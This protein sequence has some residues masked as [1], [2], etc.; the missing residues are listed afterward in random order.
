MSPETNALH[1]IQGRINL[2]PLQRWMAERGITDKGHAMHCL[3]RECFGEQAPQPFKLIYPQN[4]P[5]GIIY[6]YA[7]ADAGVLQDTAELSAAPL[8]CQALPPEL[9]ESKPMPTDW[10]TGRKIGF[11]IETRPVYRIKTGSSRTSQEI[12][13]FDI[14]KRRGNSPEVRPTREQVYI[15]WLSCLI[16]K[17][18]AATVQEAETKLLA[19][20]QSQTARKPGQKPFR[21]PNAIIRGNLTVKNGDAFTNM[22]RK[23]IGRHRAYGYGMLLLSVPHRT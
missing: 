17:A 2:K 14:E 1:L 6:G 22:L 8:Q 23:G 9:L 15:R 13:V 21:G 11:T 16:A 10:W 4:K 12:D 19:Y 20:H 5:F 3:L 7:R 18:E